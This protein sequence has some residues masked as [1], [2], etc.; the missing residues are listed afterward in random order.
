MP[1][2]DKK[3]LKCDYGENSVRIPFITDADMECLLERIDNCHNNP[4]KSPKTKITKHL[5]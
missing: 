2:N 1:K 4:K 3:I 5:I